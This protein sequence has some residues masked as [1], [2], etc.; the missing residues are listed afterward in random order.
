MTDILA[1][2]E[3]HETVLSATAAVVLVLSVSA[4]V[5]R[6]TLARGAVWCVGAV[7]A[8]REAWASKSEIDAA[9]PAGAAPEAKRTMLAI[10]AADV[11]G[12]S[13]LMGDDERATM[14]MLDVC[15]G[16]FRKHIAA[17][18][19]YVVDTAGDSVLATFKSVV[20]A[21]ACAVDVQNDLAECNADLPDDRQMLFRIGVNLGDVFQ[22]SNGTV[23]G[24]GVN[25]A[26]RL[27]SLTEPGGITVS[28]SAYMQ[29]EGKVD[30]GFQDIG[31]HEVKNIARAVRAYRITADGQAAQVAPRLSATP[32]RKPSIAV[33]PFDNMSGNAKQE[34][35]ADGMT[36][37]V[38]TLLSTVPGLFVIARNSTFAYKGQATDVRKVAA[39]LGV[40]Y[41][42][43]GSVRKA[44]NRIRVTA[45]FID[46]ESGNHIWADKYD[47]DLDD[48]FAVQDEV[49]QGIVGALQ[50]RLL[51]AEAGFLDRKPPGALDAWG[52]VVKAKIKRF[53]V[54]GEDMDEAEAF[55]RR[56]IEIDP[57]YGEAHAVLAHIL[58]WRTFNGW[59]EDW[60]QTAK[61]AVSH[62]DRALA[63]APDD[64]AVLTDVG[65]ARWLLG[66]FFNSVPILERAIALNPNAALTCALCGIALSTVDR[67][68]EGIALVEKAFRLSPRDPLEYLLHFGMAYCLFFAGQYEACKAAA[69]R[70]LQSHPD[71]A[72]AIIFRAA[73]CV[74]LDELEEARGLL[75]RVEKAGFGW[76][77][78]RLIL[79]SAEG[80]LWAEMTDAI[81]QAMDREPET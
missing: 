51:L 75:A 26:A 21:V 12:Y 63:L 38:I 78:D 24:D 73:A 47:R 81:C 37:D 76:V 77:I 30:I 13:R 39:D 14:D 5:M 29:A 46:A 11:T 48:I 28:E 4:A 20:E 2:L 72:Y 61:D 15:R 18:H 54:R 27:E 42:L 80:T 1:W 69:D 3:A 31:E 36:E 56:A 62:A 25:V 67:A 64:P 17:H 22:Q 23:Y 7:R 35:F 68:A 58:G 6:S 40:R 74:R 41:V 10:L 57:E 43:E 9:Q 49:G 65:F 60:Q 79:A 55:A 45:Q 70:S 33:L 34:Y 16:V 8:R 19:G 66:R 50:S 32:S 52:N 71:F 44:G 53:A 59:T